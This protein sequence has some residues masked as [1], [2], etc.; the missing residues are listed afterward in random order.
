MVQHR[1]YDYIIMSFKILEK[2]IISI[3]VKRSFSINSINVKIKIINLGMKVIAL[4]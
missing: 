4:V 3:D 1:Q 2:E